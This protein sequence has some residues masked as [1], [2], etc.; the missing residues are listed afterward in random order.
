MKKTDFSQLVA[1]ATQNISPPLQEVS[2]VSNKRESINEGSRQI[3][4]YIPED[5]YRKVKKLAF[6]REVSIKT[7]L[8]QSIEKYITDIS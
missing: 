8:N 5:V 7:I 2:V 3:A 1:E 4:F 6:E